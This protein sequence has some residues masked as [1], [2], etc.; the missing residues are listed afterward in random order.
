M[1]V[2]LVTDRW[3]S[4]GG[5]RE[6]YA[7]ELVDALGR[8]GCMVE[9]FCLRAGRFLS[10]RD[11]R[12]R[13][14]RGP[15][16]LADLALRRAIAVHRNAHSA[17]PILA[18]RPI[19]EATH[20]QLHSGLYCLAFEAE[21]ASFG[22]KFRRMLHPLG[23]ALNRRR[24]RLLAAERRMFAR[25]STVSVMA[26]S[27]GVARDVTRLFAL[28][29]DRLTIAPIG[30]DVERFHPAEMATDMR[31]TSDARATLRMLFVGH[32]F[33]LKGLPLVTAAMGH[34]R[35]RGLDV[36]LA[37]AGKGREAD[38]RQAARRARLDGAVTFLGPMSQDDLADCYRSSDL[39]VHPSFYDPFPR[40]VLE[41]MACG[42][43]VVTTFRCGTAE[44]MRSGVEGLLVDNPRDVDALASAIAVFA[45]RACR[46]R[47]AAAA[48]ATARGFRFADHA[49]RVREWLAS[50]LPPPVG[51]S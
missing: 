49:V 18:L 26:F 15:G 43:P 35:A 44:L 33:V 29:P 39:L 2:V 8:L 30:I 7:A 28:R 17:D 40:C 31:G 19:V 23:M 48:A 14:F 13:L 45:D 11:C 50:P 4:A 24:R 20:Y 27:N 36:T 42:C 10:S 32:S 3:D 38:M 41:A 1:R 16:P 46:N 25:E 37:V 22:S 47:M 5:G 6:R 21:R 9:V 34:L 51:V 12:V